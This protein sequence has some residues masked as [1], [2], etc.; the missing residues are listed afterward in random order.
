M[1]N[2][3]K[4]YY[5]PHFHFK[6]QLYKIFKDNWEKF[7]EV[8]PRK[9]EKRFG[10]LQ[11]YQISTVEK[12]LSCS[13]PHNGFSYVECTNESCGNSYV[14][15]F[16]CKSEICPS[17][18]EKQMLEFSDWITNEV[19]FTVKHKHT[20]L[21]MPM[22]VR[23]YFQKEPKLLSYLSSSAGKMLI[24]LTR[25]GVMEKYSKGIDRK[26]PD[27]AKPGIIVRIETAGGSLNFNPHLHCIE[28]E[29]CYSPHD[30][31]DRYY[32]G[33]FVPYNVIRHRWMNVILNLLV[34][35]GKM[36]KAEAEQLRKKYKKG[37]NVNSQIRDHIGDKDLMYRQAQY[38][39]KA[40]LS[41]TRI[42]DYNRK[43]K[44]VTIK[45]RRKD[46][47]DKRKGYSTETITA[48]ELIARL[49]QHIHYPRIH[50]TK[51]FGQYS[52][53]RRGLRRKERKR[54][55]PNEQNKM[56]TDY[57]SSWA[58]LIWKVYGKNPLKCPSCGCKMKVKEIVT[59]NV[60]EEL[61]RL[62]IAV[63]IYKED[64][65]VYKYYKRGP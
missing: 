63:W 12:F 18:S 7:I 22:E 10:E 11:E 65:E 53:K 24:E 28:T 15:P 21:T 20:V 19:L 51:Y 55:N 47:D 50:Y 52:V 43:T 37:F 46:F 4:G 16:S 9:Y 42:V 30:A 27:D 40:P 44:R 56:R 49:I 59:E 23:G 38:I 58:K 25:E 2:E 1:S 5:T 60:D 14:V 17:C 36:S 31:E 26:I 57:R 8:Y 54:A 45:F 41:E 39:Q 48:L 61:Q 29:G 13:N 34:N 62:N 6:T 33:G 32:A 3:I 64:E 35:F